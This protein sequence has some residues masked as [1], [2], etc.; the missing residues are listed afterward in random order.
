MITLHGDDDDPSVHPDADEY[1]DEIDSD[2][3]GQVAEDIAE[4]TTA[5]KTVSCARLLGFSLPAVFE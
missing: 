3:D 1:C 5:S 4:L 2:C